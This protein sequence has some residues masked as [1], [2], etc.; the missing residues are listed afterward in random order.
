[1]NKSEWNEW[2]SG[3]KEA[4]REFKNAMVALT[5]SVWSYLKG[6]IRRRS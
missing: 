1:M 2:K 5:K 3:M 4:L 6:K